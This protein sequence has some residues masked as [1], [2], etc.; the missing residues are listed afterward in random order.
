MLTP[1]AYVGDGEIE[2]WNNAQPFD[3]VTLPPMPGRARRALSRARTLARWAK[4]LKPDVLLASGDPAVYVGAWCARKY[5]IP[6][7]GVEHGRLPRRWERPIKRRF[8]GATSAVVAVS[9][10]SLQR[11]RAM[12]VKPR[13]EQ[14]ITNGAD[15]EHFRPLPPERVEAVRADLGLADRRILLTVGNMTERKG[16]DIVIRAMPRVLAKAPDARYLVVGLPTRRPQLEALAAE[17]GVKEHVHFVGRVDGERLLELY[18]A[19]DVF[20]MTSRHTA[21]EFEGYGIGVIE[22]AL[23]GKPA[24]VSASSGLMEA[25]VHGETGVGVP[26]EDPDATADAIAELFLDDGARRKLGEAARR[27]A[28][29]EGTWEHVTDRYQDLFED[30][31]RSGP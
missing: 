14:V 25:I 5:G 11:L 4:E 19:C 16:Q 20:T 17:L 10:F 31:A 27:R 13:R 3:V 24:V 15:A 12:G 7:V 2:A 26:L 22:A 6:S 8:F 9:S 23:C 18:N 30:V 1:Q 28:L 21:E 29:S